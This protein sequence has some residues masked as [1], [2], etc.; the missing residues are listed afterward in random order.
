[1]CCSFSLSSLYTVFKVDGISIWHIAETL[2]TVDGNIW[3]F[4][5]MDTLSQLA[6]YFQL[7]E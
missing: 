3:A 6:S 4:I 2:Y 1:M 7:L 5:F